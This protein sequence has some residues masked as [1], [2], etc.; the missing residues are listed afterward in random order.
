MDRRGADRSPILTEGQNREHHTYTPYTPTARPTCRGQS[1]SNPPQGGCKP[2]LP[3]LR[4]KWPTAKRAK[5]ASGGDSVDIQT[6]ERFAQ[7]QSPVRAECK[8]WQSEQPKFPANGRNIEC[9]KTIFLL[10]DC[11]AGYPENHAK[12]PSVHTSTSE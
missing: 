3:S 8:R 9:N 10:H 4:R 12:S 1:S 6:A 7:Q 5:A 2:R 11:V